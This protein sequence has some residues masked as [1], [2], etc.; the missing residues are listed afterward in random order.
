[1]AMGA[2]PR[3]ARMLVLTGVLAGFGAAPAQ[4]VTTTYAYDELGRLIA[5]ESGAPS[6]TARVKYS[7]DRMGNLLARSVSKPLF[8][9]GFEATAAT[10]L[11]ALDGGR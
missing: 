6:D 8:A 9:N 1:M 5:A 2:L 7:Y 10:P 3:A 11:Q 4:V